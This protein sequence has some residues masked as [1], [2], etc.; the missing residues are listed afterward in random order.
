MC[1][2]TYGPTSTTLVQQ[3]QLLKWEPQQELHV[4]CPLTGFAACR[5]IPF[6]A[7]KITPNWTL[8]RWQQMRLLP[9]QPLSASLTARALPLNGR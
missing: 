8:L 3:K 9:A 2:N 7:I 6:A 5:P 1:T 4:A